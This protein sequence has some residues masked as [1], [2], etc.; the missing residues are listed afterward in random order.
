MKDFNLKK[1]LLDNPLTNKELKS[2]KINEAFE[3]VGGVLSLRPVNEAPMQPKYFDTNEDPWGWD[4]HVKQMRD[5][6][7]GRPNKWIAD[8]DRLQPRHGDWMATWEY[9][10]II[11]WSHPDIDNAVVVATPGWDGPGT[12]VEFQSG[13]GSSQMLK[14]LDQD[15][16]PTIKDYIAAVAPYLDMVADANDVNVGGYED[17]P[18]A[19]FQGVHEAHSDLSQDGKDLDIKPVIHTDDMKEGLPNMKT[20]FV[21]DYSSGKVFSKMVP[22]DMQSEEIESMLA[23]EYGMLPND[24]Y[25]MVTNSSEVEDLDDANMME[26]SMVFDKGWQYDDDEEDLDLTRIDGLID[27][28]ELAKYSEAVL[29]IAQDLQD[30]GFEIYDI[31]GFLKS[32]LDKIIM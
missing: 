9:P 14:V 15:Q 30:H 32:Q 17:A 7:E 11:T 22:A 23:D 10:G 28:R 31:K 12:P 6:E 20:L 27:Q 8:I 26:G 2:G 4:K 21:M 18:E 19:E 29:A 1:F 16:F 24:I 3:G 25:Y 13:G 5:D